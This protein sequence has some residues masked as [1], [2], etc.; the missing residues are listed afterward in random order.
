MI[1]ANGSLKDVHI[2]A[3]KKPSEVLY[4]EEENHHEKWI[5][6]CKIEKDYFRQ[7]IK[8]IGSK[9]ETLTLLTFIK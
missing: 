5:F 9:N 4:Q 2:K 6:L 8:L 7:T 1:L 3:L